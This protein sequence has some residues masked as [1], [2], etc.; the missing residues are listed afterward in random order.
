MSETHS[1]ANFLVLSD[2]LYVEQIVQSSLVVVF[3]QSLVQD[4]LG[5]ELVS[6]QRDLV[7]GQEAALQVSQNFIWSK[8]HDG[9][10]GGIPA[11]RSQ[12]KLL[13]GCHQVLQVW[14][15]GGKSVRERVSPRSCVRR[16]KRLS[17][18]THL[19][20]KQHPPLS[21]ALAPVLNQSQKQQSVGR[22]QRFLC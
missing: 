3:G 9:L 5:E 16:G 22:Y 4:R 18:Q 8:L 21:A 10:A 19:Q 6:R 2:L 15:R 12:Q 17:N 20:W 1:L 7:A 14:R 13:P 11:H